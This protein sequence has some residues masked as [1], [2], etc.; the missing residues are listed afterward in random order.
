MT[1][2]ELI[3]A[4]DAAGVEDEDELYLWTQEGSRRVISGVDKDDEVFVKYE[5]PN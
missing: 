3:A 4:M 1:R 5:F 2:A